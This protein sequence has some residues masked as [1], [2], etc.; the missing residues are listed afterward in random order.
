MFHTGGNGGVIVNC[1]PLETFSVMFVAILRI[2][3]L[4]AI[5]MCLPKPF[6]TFAQSSLV[7]NSILH[8]VYYIWCLL[9]MLDTISLLSLK[10]VVSSSRSA[11]LVLESSTLFCTEQLL[12]PAIF[13]KLWF[14][15]TKT[16][17]IKCRHGIL[18]A[19]PT[20]LPLACRNMAGVVRE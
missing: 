16:K 2:N 13:I 7:Y 3:F 12:L 4:G 10:P 18:P 19:I 5:F 17:Q 11:I 14:Y 6:Y 20:C 15:C 1:Q 8:P 9:C